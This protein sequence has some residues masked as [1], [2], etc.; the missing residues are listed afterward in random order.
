MLCVKRERRG[1]SRGRSGLRRW[2]DPCYSKVSTQPVP[3]RNHMT[4]K[5]E[6]ENIDKYEAWRAAVKLFIARFDRRTSGLSV[7][8]AE[9]RAA[10]DDMDQKRRAFD[11]S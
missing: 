8:Q 10:A 6:D 1:D 5:T 2:Y 4:E 3:A 11:A 9:V 7:G